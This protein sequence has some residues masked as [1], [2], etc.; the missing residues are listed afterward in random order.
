MSKAILHSY[1]DQLE[2]CDTAVAGPLT[3]HFVRLRP[4][5]P[6]RGLNYRPVAEA[7]A[8]GAVKVVEKSAAG[9]VNCLTLSNESADRV[10]LLGGEIL[11]GGKQDRLVNTDVLVEAGSRTD[12]P[13]S[14][15][16]RNRWRYVSQK[17][18]SGSTGTPSLRTVLSKSV[19]AS[20][21]T[22]G[23]PTS[24]QLRVWAQV[25]TTATSLGTHSATSNL[26]EHYAS[27]QADLAK[28]I[29]GIRAPADACGMIVRMGDE[30]HAT[31]IFDRAD[32]FG[33]YCRK[34]LE[35]Y[36]AEAIGR[37]TSGA[38]RADAGADGSAVLPP[39]PSSL[40]DGVESTEH[41]GVGL[42]TEVRLKSPRAEG[43]ALVFGDA[44]VHVSLFVGT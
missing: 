13:V 10:F 7:L 18:E 44:V 5:T 29:D 38:K 2:V 3:V 6:E 14:C 39:D 27:R 24:D 34:L 37:A 26:S 20:Y 12:V 16:E 9:Q 35:G 1:L 33:R 22:V 42:G 30:R 19:T 23:T 41:A 32:T 43:G 11:R 15:V 25:D 17:F 4:R 40:L 21:E 31:D 36:G 28:V 8:T